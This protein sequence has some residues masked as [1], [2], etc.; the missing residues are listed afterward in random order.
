MSI[1]AQYITIIFLIASSLF[2]LNS[3][4][5]FFEFDEKALGKYF[6]FK[7]ILVGHIAGGATALLTGPIQFLKPFR[8]KFM[9]AHRILG[10]S[11]LIS[12]V[13]SAF[14]AF[15]LTLNTTAIVG[16]GYTLS[17]HVLIFAWLSTSAIAFATILKGQ[18]VSHQQWMVRSYICTFAFIV[19]NYLLKIPAFVALG[20]FA[21]VAQAMIW[22]SWSVPLLVY[23]IVLTYQTKP[24][25]LRKDLAS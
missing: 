6:P 2:F 12:V 11:Y 9:R 24:G 23:Q 20:T 8:N 1:R 15:I 22:F 13:V 7:W 21:E 19:Q 16:V 14:F 3:Y 25:S 18:V 5:H 4:T 10:R 17:L